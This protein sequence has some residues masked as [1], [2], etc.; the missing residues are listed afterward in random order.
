ML[1]VRVKD[2]RKCR[3]V[4]ECKKKKKKRKKERKKGSAEFWH[5][6]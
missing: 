4:K 3:R 2:T 5:R 6:F 1:N